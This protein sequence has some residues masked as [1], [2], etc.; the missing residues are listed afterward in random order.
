MQQGSC[1]S[2]YKLRISA[3]QLG[4]DRYHYFVAE[5]IDSNNAAIVDTLSRNSLPLFHGYAEK[6][7]K[8]HSKALSLKKDCHFFF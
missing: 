4:I 5:R 6:E 3:K 7:N 8:S 1:C 2:G